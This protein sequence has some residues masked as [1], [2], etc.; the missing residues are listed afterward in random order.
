MLNIL[1]I[2]WGFLLGGASRYA[3]VLEGIKS[4]APISSHSLCILA[5]DWVTDRAG[6]EHLSHTIIPIGGRLD[7]SW[8]AKVANEIEQRRP[9]LVM[10]HSYNS[11]FVAYSCA[12]LLHRR[13]PII[14]SYHGPYHAATALRHVT[15]FFYNRF[16]N[17]F[18]R[19]HTMGVVAVAEH[20]KRKLVSQGIPEN[21]IEV[22]HN[23]ITA[24]IS[25][26][27]QKLRDEFRHQWKVA[28]EE[29]VIGC[30]G[31]LDPVKGHQY[32]IQA[33]RHIRSQLPNIRLVII[34]DG[35]LRSRIERQVHDYKLDQC[36]ILTGSLPEASRVLP[37]FDIYALPSLSECHSI[38]L[39]EAMRAGLPIVATAVGGNSESITHEQDGL[40][41]PPC[42]SGALTQ[43][44][45]RLTASLETRRNFG[46]AAR[47][48][49]LREFSE[50]TML[51]RT[52]DWLLRC[53]QNARGQTATKY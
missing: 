36:V 28:P 7:R 20:A 38:A 10:T 12:R 43:A 3:R 30:V 41:V 19:R 32:L 34:G 11:H 40:L 18:L 51:Q 25:E 49:F 22:I 37:A 17:L 29:I 24:E 47:A 48:R 53:G 21:R 14:S 5:P 46:M 44:L 8:K 23:G 50:E 39:L 2:H 4:V 13:L 9:D 26:D 35:P 52:A 27:P 42:N 45:T 31:R 1:Q 15:G 6:L 16:T 33:V